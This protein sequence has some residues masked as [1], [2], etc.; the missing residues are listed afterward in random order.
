M[1]NERRKLGSH[2]RGMVKL[3]MIAALMALI[4]PMGALAQETPTPSSI[5]VQ[6]RVQ[7]L[8]AAPEL[9]K[10][11]VSFNYNTALEEF[12]YGDVSDWK[13]IPPGATQIT[14]NADRAGFNYLVFNAIYPIQAGN[15]YYSVITDQLLINGVFDRSP[16][17]DGGARIVVVQGSVSLPAVN[18]TATGQKAN[19]ATNLS[20]PR[21]SE[22]TVVPAG[23]YDINVTLA[24]GGQTA[25]SVPGVSLAGDSTNV[26]VIMG[27]ANDTDNPL[28]IKTLSDTTTPKTSGS[29]TETPSS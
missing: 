14:M 3:L 5:A 22:S 8:H 23:T 16:I 12:S 29:A 7:F 19:F 15:D 24:D 26:I 18:V 21:T 10:V 2:R 9:G 25:L 28:T 6:T 27:T 1:R 11:E 13:D 20:Y 4:G 17:P